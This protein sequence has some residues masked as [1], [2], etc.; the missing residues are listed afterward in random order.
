[1][2]QFEQIR[3]DRD[4]EGLSIRPLAAWYGVHRRAARQ[5]LVSPVPLPKRPPSKLGAYRELI[6]DWLIADL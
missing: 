5:A 6:D 1:M 2:E 3:R 4:R